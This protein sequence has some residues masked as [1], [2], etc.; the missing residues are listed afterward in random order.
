[1]NI[2][3]RG[4]LVATMLVILTTIAC[5]SGTNNDGASE[6]MGPEVRSV[7]TQV[8]KMLQESAQSLGNSQLSTPFGKAINPYLASVREAGEL[9]RDHA[10]AFQ[11]GDYNTFVYVAMNLA[12]FQAAK[13]LGSD[14][15]SSSSVE[16]D[17][18]AIQALLAEA[19]S[20]KV[21]D[22]DNADLGS[23]AQRLL[24]FLAEVIF[25]SDKGIA[26]QLVPPDSPLRT[27]WDGDGDGRIQPPLPPI[28][29]NTE[30]DPWRQFSRDLT[31]EAD[32]A[33]PIAIARLEIQSTADKFE[34][35]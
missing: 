2:L 14:L 29:V 3:M 6:S 7:A 11:N 19:D 23:E 17:G 24:E 22:L 34:V 15:A 12:G 35:P 25:I 18:E 8:V 31:F 21:P 4:A 1:V 26:D 33:S 5:S 28:A 32:R 27:N 13:A 30:P 9:F 16:T 20:E 10:K